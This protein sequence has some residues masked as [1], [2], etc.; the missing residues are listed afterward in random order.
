MPI[1]K[2]HITGNP[3]LRIYLRNSKNDVAAGAD[4]Y[5]KQ[6][7]LG[8]K[9]GSNRPPWEN[10]MA[11][12]RDILD[13]L[14]KEKRKLKINRVVAEDLNIIELIE[15]C[16]EWKLKTE[17]VG[18]NRS[19]QYI[20]Y[21]R[22][23]IKP[24]VGHLKADKY[25][26]NWHQR[27]IDYVIDNIYDQKT[28]KVI[29][30]SKDQDSTR[31]AEIVDRIVRTT[32]KW[33]VSQQKI[34]FNPLDKYVTTGLRIKPKNAKQAEK[35]EQ[36][37]LEDHE[38][39]EIAKELENTLF[40]RITILTARLGTRGNE[41]IGL[42]WR[43][44]DC[45]FNESTNQ[46]EGTMDINRQVYYEEQDKQWT[47]IPPKWNSYGTLDLIEADVLLLK[48]W[49]EIQKL[50]FLELGKR[51][52]KKTWIFTSENGDHLRLHSWRKAVERA[53]KRASKRASDQ[54]RRNKKAKLIRIVSS[55]QL[56][57]HYHAST[58]ITDPANKGIGYTVFHIAQKRLRHKSLE[59]TINNYIHLRKDLTKSAVKTASTHLPNV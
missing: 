5:W 21:V 19:N 45:W 11:E 52:T 56:L 14:K 31:N 39:I 38:V 36:I 44:F 26:S 7:Y 37:F 13:K 54:S 24:Q 50:Q 6:E 28:N 8:S 3:Y 25:T 51:V 41:S 16:R 9:E 17:Q 48:E 15:Q 33:A 12:A 23:W 2:L 53:S 42:Q 10:R 34:E 18:S 43:D 55:I 20:Q 57:R 32:F 47:V 46:W 30:R 40:K 1:E 58:I 22:A 29:K 35:K 59:T 49:S 4:Y 27:L